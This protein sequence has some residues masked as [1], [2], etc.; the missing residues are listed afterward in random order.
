M[1]GDVVVIELAGDVD[2]EIQQDKVSDVEQLSSGQPG[3]TALVA[4]SRT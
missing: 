4:A 1:A 2:G 3:A